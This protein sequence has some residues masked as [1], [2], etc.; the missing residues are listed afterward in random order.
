MFH[1]LGSNIL[2]PSVRFSPVSLHPPWTEGPACHPWQEHSWLLFTLASTVNSWS[3]LAMC[4]SA[5]HCLCPACADASGYS[6]PAPVLCASPC[7]TS[8]GC[9]VPRWH[10]YPG[11]S[12]PKFC[13]SVSQPCSRSSAISSLRRVCSVSFS[14]SFT[15][16]LNNMGPNMLIG[17]PAC[18]GLPSRP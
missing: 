11:V 7:W 4:H 8:Q 1:A 14:R 3:F 13:F 2:E 9:S 12:G 10:I 5:C 15:K 16:T 6:T 18:N 17:Y